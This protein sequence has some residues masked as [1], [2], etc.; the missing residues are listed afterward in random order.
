MVRM[1][2]HQCQMRGGLHIPAA[3]WRVTSGS[4]DVLPYPGMTILP[5]A[6]YASDE[7]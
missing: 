6:F 5:H 7:H 4:A 1:A 2:G 3:E